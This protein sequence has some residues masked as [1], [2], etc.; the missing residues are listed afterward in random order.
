MRI[1][2]ILV[3]FPIPEHVPAFY[4]RGTV[5]PW[6][7]PQRAVIPVEIT[8]YSVTFFVAM[9]ISS[10]R[11]TVVLDALLSLP[12]QVFIHRRRTVRRKRRNILPDTSSCF[13]IVQIA[14]LTVILRG[15]IAHIIAQLILTDSVMLAWIRVAFV[16]IVQFAIRTGR[17]N[18]TITNIP[19]LFTPADAAVLASGRLAFVP[20]RELAIFSHKSIATGA[21][22][23]ASMR[24]R[25]NTAILTRRRRTE[26]HLPFAV[27]S[28]V[29]RL[30]VAVVIV[31]QLHAVQRTGV[32]ARIREALVNVPLASRSHKT[33]QTLALEAAHLI[34]A[35]PVIV[36]R[37]RPAVVDVDFAHVAQ[38]AGR[39]R[40]QE[41]VD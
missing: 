27:P 38:R 16:R 22:M 21:F 14:I 7:D 8:R 33:W 36:A 24:H 28:I 11:W 25:T 5:R 15:A 23:S 3:A 40:A 29:P 20:A 6:V 37:V 39:T 2:A 18:R 41:T 32:R 34:N 12:F 19:A 4:R 10:L 13:R 1:V 31:H 35:R 17:P 9:Q 26:V 30:A